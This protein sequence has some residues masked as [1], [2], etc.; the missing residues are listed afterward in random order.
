MNTEIKKLLKKRPVGDSIK[1][2]PEIKNTAQMLR[3]ESR[4]SCQWLVAARRAPVVD[5]PSV[6]PHC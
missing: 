3:P 1:S 2:L 6:K 5:L 4:S